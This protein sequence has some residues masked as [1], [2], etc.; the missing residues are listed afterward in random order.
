MA[1][2]ENER[3]KTPLSKRVRR[4]N[5]VRGEK[6][7]EIGEP[8]RFP[9]PTGIDINMMP[10]VLGDFD[11]IPPEYREPYFHLL[12]SSFHR[13]EETELDKVGYL[14][15]Q[16]SEV[17]A[18]ESQ[19]RGGL[20]TDAHPMEQG[21]GE[22]EGEGG[23]A[24]KGGGDLVFPGGW[25]GMTGG[26]YMASSCPNTTKVWD[27]MVEEPGLHGDCEELREVLG[28]GEI[29]PHDTLLWITDRTPHESLPMPEGGCRSFFRIVTSDVSVW[30]EQHSTPNPLGI[31][32]PPNVRI[33]TENKFAAG[34]GIVLK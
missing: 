34:D 23:L 32:P 21:E 3:G 18:G 7:Y 8:V 11:S 5:F 13:M 28:K 26:I 1:T 15:I 20:H 4:P 12:V 25:G 10:I 16:E 27:A 33:V 6:A 2:P 17:M 14:T 9:S 29:A 22:G 19:R 31:C 24:G 30:Y